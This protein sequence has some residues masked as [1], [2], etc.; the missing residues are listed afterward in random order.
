MRTLELG[1][2]LGV[3]VEVTK[4]QQ[5]FAPD[6]NAP[7]LPAARH[8]DEVERRRKLDVDAELVLERRDCAQESVTLGH[9]K[10]VDVDRRLP[11]ADKDR[12]RST[13]EVTAA[14]RIR[15]APQR[16]HEAFDARGVC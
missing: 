14:L 13:G 7:I 6:R 4:A 3:E 16:G 2:R 5:T 12:G 10:D 9:E 11:P 1:E 8:R 15:G